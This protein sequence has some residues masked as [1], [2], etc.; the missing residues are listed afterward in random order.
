ML[1]D[2][3]RGILGLL[4]VAIATWLANSITDKIFGPEDTVSKA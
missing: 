2:L 1:R 3:V 4:L